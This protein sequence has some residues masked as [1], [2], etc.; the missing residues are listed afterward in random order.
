MAAKVPTKM[1]DPIRITTLTR[2]WKRLVRAICKSE[3]LVWLMGLPR[4]TASAAVRGLVLIQID[5]LSKAQLERAI[6]EGRMPFV[7]KLLTREN[8][9]NHTM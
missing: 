7:K 4:S 6:E 5:G 3:W 1:K 2:L 9:T 8:Y